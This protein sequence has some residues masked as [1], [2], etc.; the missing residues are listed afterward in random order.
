V[1]NAWRWP[2][3]ALVLAVCN[4]SQRKSG[5]SIKGFDSLSDLHLSAICVSYVLT[6]VHHEFDEDVSI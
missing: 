4:V 3:R 5:A 2:F 6:S 1:V